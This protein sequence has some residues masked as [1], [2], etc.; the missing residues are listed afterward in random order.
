MCLRFVLILN[1]LQA[2]GSSNS[3][4]CSPPRELGVP[5]RICVIHDDV[6]ELWVVNKHCDPA[7]VFLEKLLS[8]LQSGRLI[9]N[10]L[11]Q[12]RH[13]TLAVLSLLRAALKMPT[14]SQRHFQACPCRRRDV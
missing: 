5:R 3:S 6:R 1:G 13:G 9:S 2:L 7:S 12:K 4:L 8:V 10:G 11:K 14:H